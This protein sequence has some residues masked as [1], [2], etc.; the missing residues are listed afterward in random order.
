M[1]RGAGFI[2]KV[3]RGPGSC[4]IGKGRPPKEQISQDLFLGRGRICSGLSHS[5]SAISDY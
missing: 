1:D 4:R 2:S 5:W 3:W